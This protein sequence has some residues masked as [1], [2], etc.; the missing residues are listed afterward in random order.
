MYLDTRQAASHLNVSPQFL[1]KARHFGDGPQYHALTPR[2]IRYRRD[3]LDAWA[4]KNR[5]TCT[6]DEPEAA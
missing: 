6:R 5:R 1:E 2:C 4:A 3:D